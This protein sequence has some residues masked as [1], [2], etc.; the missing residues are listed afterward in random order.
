MNDREGVKCIQQ[1][2]DSDGDAVMYFNHVFSNG[3]E[4]NKYV[5]FSE[6]LLL[7]VRSQTSSYLYKSV[8]ISLTLKP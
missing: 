7:I 4:C 1:H 5:L 8:I 3:T 2:L 6:L